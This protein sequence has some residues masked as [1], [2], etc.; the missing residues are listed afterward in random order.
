MFGESFIFAAA[1]ASSAQMSLDKR[2]AEVPV[3]WLQ[4]NAPHGFDITPDGSIWV[5]VGEDRKGSVWGLLAKDLLNVGDA[6]GRVWVRGYHRDDPSVP[7]RETKEQIYFSC[8]FN[9][10]ATIYRV[11]YAADGS[12][13]NEQGPFSSLGTRPIIPGSLAQEWASYVCK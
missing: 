4:E 7:Y 9:E 2:L 5:T 13:M 11:T 12:I 6:G 3:E 10:Y 8:K 1:F